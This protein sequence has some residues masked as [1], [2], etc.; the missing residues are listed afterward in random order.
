[1]ILFFF[2]IKESGYQNKK[3]NQIRM[4]ISCWF[5]SYKY[6]DFTFSVLLYYIW[7]DKWFSP[8]YLWV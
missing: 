1:M 3:S 5:L 2:Y 4:F 6:Q 7:Y 8:T